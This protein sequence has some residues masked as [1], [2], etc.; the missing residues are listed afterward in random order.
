[1]GLDREK[2]SPEVCI[3]KYYHD[4]PKQWPSDM[5]LKDK[6][7]IWTPEKNLKLI[8]TLLISIKKLQRSLQNLQ[9]TL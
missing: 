7:K 1:M 3:K 9:K 8:F 6:P 4:A 2:G 5:V